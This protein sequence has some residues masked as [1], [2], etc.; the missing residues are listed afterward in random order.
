MHTVVQGKQPAPVVKN[1]VF[2]RKLQQRGH[3]EIHR[4][5]G[6]SGDVREGNAMS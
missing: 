5:M 1:K 6:T 4:E 2:A 3:D